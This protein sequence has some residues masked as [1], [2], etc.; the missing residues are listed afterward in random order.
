MKV[1]RLVLSIVMLTTSAVTYGQSPSK[2]A[3]ISDAQKNFDLMKTLVGTWQGSLTSD[4]PAWSTDKPIA[5]SIRVG[6]HGNA[7]IHELNTGTPEVTVF[8]VESDRLALIHYCDFGNRPHMVARPSTDGK[9]VEFEL[10]DF[11]GSNAVG[12]VSH[13]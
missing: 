3:A 13:G 5:L 12:H 1:V 2:A 11:S 4:N 10:V 8:Y 7:L 9:T 6:S